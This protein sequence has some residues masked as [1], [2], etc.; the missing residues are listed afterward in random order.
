MLLNLA[1]QLAR[2]QM[3][4]LGR[5]QASTKVSLGGDLHGY[6]TIWNE[7]Y[8]S[9][10][11]NDPAVVVLQEWWGVND[12]IKHQAQIIADQGYVAVIPDIYRGKV[13][14]DVAEAQHLMDGLDWERAVKDIHDTVDH[15][16]VENPSR[17]IG[18]VGFC[19][20]GA[21]SFLAASSKASPNSKL[22]CAI[23]FYGLPSDSVVE[24]LVRHGVP[25]QGHFGILDAHSGFSDP[26]TVRSFEKKLK[27]AGSLHEP[28]HF[29][30]TQGHGFMN[31]TPWYQK[32][33]VELG[34]PPTDQAA[35]ASAWGSVFKFF[36]QHLH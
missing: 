14:L 23:S 13:A 6:K 10:T 2:A 34:R 4:H 31:V 8:H 24:D 11:P 12:E 17:K 20:G 32:V 5:M 19:M 28:F 30:D 16:R 15:L 35:I 21:L 33:R 18:I 1:R 22:N 3:G 25:I 26:K 29:Y 36:K 7:G 9:D 27:L